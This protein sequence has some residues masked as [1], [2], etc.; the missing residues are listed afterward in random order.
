MVGFGDAKDFCLGFFKS[1]W[2]ETSLGLQLVFVCE[3]KKLRMGWWVTVLFGFQ[4]YL[5]WTYLQFSSQ[6]NHRGV[7]IPF[8]K[9]FH[10][11]DFSLLR[12]CFCVVSFGLG[13]CS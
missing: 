12:R 1:V 4:S 5:C 10:S 2:G 6:W 7:S 13:C 8:S 9:A 11:R 3:G